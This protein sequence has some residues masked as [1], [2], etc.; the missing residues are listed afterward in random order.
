M[1]NIFQSLSGCSKWDLSTYKQSQ[2]KPATNYYLYFALKRE[3]EVSDAV[4][5]F[6]FM[7]MNPGI[8]GDII[9]VMNANGAKENGSRPYLN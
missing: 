7:M 4:I 3:S 6:L 5:K 8:K 2:I 1:L 9:T